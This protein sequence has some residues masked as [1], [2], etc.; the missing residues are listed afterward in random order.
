MVVAA[1]SSAT[2]AVASTAPASAAAAS[3][4]YASAGSAQTSSAQNVVIRV[5][6]GTDFCVAEFLMMGSYSDVNVTWRPA[7]VCCFWISFSRLVIAYFSRA[8]SLPSTYGT[9]CVLNRPG[10]FFEP[11]T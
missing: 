4:W 5:A 9:D 7:V 8:S 6:A 3:P 1:A 10:D 2:V 11:G